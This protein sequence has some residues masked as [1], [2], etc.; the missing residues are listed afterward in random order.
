MLRQLILGQADAATPTGAPAAADAAAAPPDDGGI[1]DARIP[2]DMAQVE[3]DF[4]NA[5]EA[6]MNGDV[7]GTMPLVENYLLPA[8]MALL[9]LIVGYFIAKALSRIISGPVTKRVDETLG[10]FI[11]KLAFYVLMAVVLIAVL[12]KVGVEVTSFAAIM[13]AAGFA[14]GLAFQGTLSNFASG[15]LLLV[16][17]PFKVGDVINA[18]GITA[19]VYEIDLFTTTFNTPDNR[20]IVVPNSA[21]A[22]GTIENVT[23]HKERRIDIS[24]GVAYDADIDKTRAVL[25]AAAESLKDKLVEGEGRGCQIVLTDLGACSVNW[26]IRFWTRAADFW[27]VKEALIRAVK[28]K[29]DEAAIGIPFPQME[30]HVR[31]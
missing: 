14:V 9:I 17:R 8:G 30:V 24:V 22:A 3:R 26:T 15:V 1:L 31:Q 5:W 28:M 7:A 27:L 19:S 2:T 13:A 11:G 4:S 6:L 25:A 21:I 20:R 23:F 10:R 16:F 12:G 29:L 18:A